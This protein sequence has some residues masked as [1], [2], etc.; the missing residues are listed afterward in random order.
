MSFNQDS[1]PEV[2]IYG[3]YTMVRT[4]GRELDQTS[5]DEL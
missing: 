3:I 1:F 4:A 2:R 5:S